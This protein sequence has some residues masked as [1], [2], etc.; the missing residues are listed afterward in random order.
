MHHWN[1]IR[2]MLSLIDAGEVWL[3]A[4]SWQFY[5]CTSYSNFFCKKYI[6]GLLFWINQNH[7]QSSFRLDILHSYRVVGNGGGLGRFAG[8]GMCPPIIFSS[9][10]VP[11]NHAYMSFL[12]LIPFRL[13]N[14][15]LVL[16]YNFTVSGLLKIKLIWCVCF[17]RV[18]PKILAFWP[19]TSRSAPFFSG[20]GACN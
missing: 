18:R 17:H 2:Q 5:G 11:F 20:L 12:S 13:V 3:A 16:I 15:W 9:L 19:L 8:W 7:F 6:R 10:N 14:Y 1:F 4:V